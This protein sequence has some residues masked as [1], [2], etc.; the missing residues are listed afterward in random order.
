M[1]LTSTCNWILESSCATCFLFLKLSQKKPEIK[2]ME[3]KPVF[4]PNFPGLCT[5]I[6]LYLGSLLWKWWRTLHQINI[7]RVSSLR[8]ELYF[9]YKHQVQEW[10]LHSPHISQWRRS[11]SPVYV[12]LQSPPRWGYCRSK[13]WSMFNILLLSRREG[14][15]YLRRI[16]STGNSTRVSRK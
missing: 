7:V 10:N 11:C 2:N 5:S 9:N 8:S 15:D 1:K 6:F 12:Q 4:F 3:I 14:E 13:T 16:Q